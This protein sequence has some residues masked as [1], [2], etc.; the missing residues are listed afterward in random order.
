LLRDKG[1]WETI[2]EVDNT[3]LEYKLQFPLTV[4]NGLQILLQK[5][6]PVKGKLPNKKLGYGIVHLRAKRGGKG[7][8]I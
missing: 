2:K 5:F 7:A 3:E 4:A 1:Q 6:D 8:V